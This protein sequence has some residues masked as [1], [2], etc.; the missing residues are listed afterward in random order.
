MK[1]FTKSNMLR[2][3]LIATAILAIL[4]IWVVVAGEWTQIHFQI[5]TTTL[6]VYA[7]GVMCLPCLYAVEQD[8]FPISG[9]S[10]LIAIGLTA[11]QSLGI[12]WE[13]Y[14]PSGELYEKGLICSWIASTTLFGALLTHMASTSKGTKWLPVATSYGMLVLGGIFI[15]SILTESDPPI[16]LTICIAIAVTCGFISSWIL[17]MIQW[18]A[19]KQAAPA[20]EVMC[21]RCGTAREEE[22][23]EMSCANCQAV[24]TVRNAD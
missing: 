16:E 22:S 7:C 10:G 5:M 14:E 13:V 1:I 20:G 17:H 24:F 23:G 11:L 2:G 4:G 9:V 3:A 19:A 21:P 18:L 12:I 8:K 6:V 15:M